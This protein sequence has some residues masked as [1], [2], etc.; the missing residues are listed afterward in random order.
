[1]S[2]TQ[3]HPQGA[4]TSCSDSASAAG[5]AAAAG[6]G[7]QDR[8]RANAYLLTCACYID[9]YKNMHIPKSMDYVYIRVYVYKCIHIYIYIFIH[10]CLVRVRICMT[11]HF[12]AHD[13]NLRCVQLA[14]SWCPLLISGCPRRNLRRSIR[15]L[16]RCCGCCDGRGLPARGR[17]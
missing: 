4:A 7:N 14:C 1:M 15:P 2:H 8:P 13:A 10:T 11:T 9:R 17:L 5:S 12:A 3:S 6:Q 16:P